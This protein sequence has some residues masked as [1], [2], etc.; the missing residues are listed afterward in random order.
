MIAIYTS[1]QFVIC[2]EINNCKGPQRL[3]QPAL[4]KHKEEEGHSQAAASLPAKPTVERTGQGEVVC[5]KLKDAPGRNWCNETS[6]GKRKR[7]PKKCRRK[8][9]RKAEAR[10]E[11]R[12][13]PN[14]FERKPK[15]FIADFSTLREE[16]CAVLAEQSDPGVYTFVDKG[17]K[18][19]NRRLS[20][21]CKPAAC[22]GCTVVLWAF[23]SLSGE[24]VQLTLRKRGKHGKLSQLSGGRL[25]TVS[26]E[27]CIKQASSTA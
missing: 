24:K 18:G 5:F 14:I 27:H 21:S 23:L 4:M 10:G 16:V 25:W 13:M 7:P 19:A 9:A 15:K 6:Q 8:V 2:L 20:A 26:E 22:E 17:V 11:P 12:N 3:H 1:M